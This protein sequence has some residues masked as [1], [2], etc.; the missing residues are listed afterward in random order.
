VIAGSAADLTALFTE[1]GGLWEITRTPDGYQARRR[2]LPVFP[3]VLT[4]ETVPALRELLKHGYDTAELAAL[5]RDFAAGWDI[6][7]LDSGSAW[8]AVSRDSGYTQ[9]IT[10]PD[11]SSLRT[12]LTLARDETDGAAK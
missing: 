11:L 1:F 3:L 12:N 2:P 9:V 4:A 8:V 7:H 5:Q 10:A 6:E